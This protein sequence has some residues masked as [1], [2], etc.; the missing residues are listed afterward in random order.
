VSDALQCNA[1]FS[2]A[3]MPVGLHCRL[4]PADA[5]NAPGECNI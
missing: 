3:R 5:R 2:C 4:T 1:T